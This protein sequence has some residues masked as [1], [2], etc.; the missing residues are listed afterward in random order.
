MVFGS[1]VLLDPAVLGSTFAR[2]SQLGLQLQ[3]LK[4]NLSLILLSQH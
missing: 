2:Y 1:R 4:S 3:E